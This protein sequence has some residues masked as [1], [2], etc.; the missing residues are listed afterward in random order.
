MDDEL[1]LDSWNIVTNSRMTPSWREIVSLTVLVKL[2]S[3]SGLII[4]GY[5]GLIN[6]FCGGLAK[7]ESVPDTLSH[8]SSH[9]SDAESMIDDAIYQVQH[10]ISG[11]RSPQTSEGHRSKKLLQQ[12]GAIR[13]ANQGEW[14]IPVWCRMFQQTLDGPAK[15]WF[16]LRRKYCK[17]PTEVAKIVRRANKMLTDFKERWTKEISYIPDVPVFM[18]I[19]ACMS[20]SKC[21]EFARRFFDQVPQTVTKMMKRVEDF[22]K[23]EEVLRT[24]SYQKG[25]TQRVQWSAIQGKRS[26]S[27]F[28]WQQ[29]FESRY[30]LMGRSLST[31]RNSSSTRRK[32]EIAM[33]SGKLNHLIKDVRQRGGDRGRQ[34]GNNNGWRKVTNMVRQ[35]IDLLHG[36]SQELLLNVSRI[37]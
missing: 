29:T 19:S 18:Q 2:A 31:T 32:L 11:Q 9:T 3:Y 28:I 27:P 35:I 22:M 26:S 20:N 8:W 30:L 16:A 7:S 21:P 4:S 6:L 23:S 15:G 36:S 14:E 33:E 13:A 12:I 1:I 37:S 17:D 5:R 34:I 10:P 25:N 24:Q